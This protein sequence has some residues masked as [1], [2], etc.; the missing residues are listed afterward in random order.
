MITKEEF[1]KAENI[2]S[3]YNKQI[4]KELIT[5]RTCCICKTNIIKPINEFTDPL[6]QENGMWDGGTVEKVSFGYGSRHDCESYYIAICD[7]CLDELKSSGFAT[8]L[9]DIKKE[10]KGNL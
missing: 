3:E 4:S 9:D 1:K 10:L 2:I 5:D 6:K 8:D 7:G